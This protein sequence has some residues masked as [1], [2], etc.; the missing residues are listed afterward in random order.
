MVILT[1]NEIELSP[2]LAQGINLLSKKIIFLSTE[3]IKW[4]KTGIEH[5][6]E[7]WKI[8]DNPPQMGNIRKFQHHLCFSQVQMR[9]E[10]SGDRSAENTTLKYWE[11]TVWKVLYFS[12]DSKWKVQVKKMPEENP[13][14][15][16]NGSYALFFENFPAG[17]LKLQ[18]N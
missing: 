8:A 2:P 1:L 12:I 6:A 4:R 7:N 10:Q 13:K 14:V 16:S 9:S 15:Q 11:K 3:R 5:D 18:Q 17:L